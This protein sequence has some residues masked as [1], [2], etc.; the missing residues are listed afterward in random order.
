M[1]LSNDIGI[2]NSLSQNR[3]EEFGFDLF[4][5]FVI[6]PI[7]ET[8]DFN[9]SAKSKI[10]I[11]GRG[12]GKTMLLRYLSHQTTFSGLKK[13]I[14][15]QEV[16][17]IGLYWKV[18]TH[19][20]YQ[21]QKRG[22]ESDIWES[23]FEHLIT[24]VLSLELI[25]SLESIADSN[26]S[27]FSKANLSNIKFGKLLEPFKITKDCDITDLKKHLKSELSNFHFW[28]RNVRKGICPQFLPKL[29]FV[30]LVEHVKSE[31][32]GLENSNFNIYIDE[33]ENLV[34]YQ[35]RI[36]NTWVKHSE[37]P[38]IFHLAMKRNAFKIRN[39]IGNESLS[40][41]H[42]YRIH[43]LEENFINHKDFMVFSA[44]I[45]IYRLQSQSDLIKEKFDSDLL[46]DPEKYQL[47]KDEK[48]QN[49]ILSIVE[50]IF[51]T[52]SHKDLANDIS[53]DAKLNKRINE[54]LKQ[55]LELR[56]SEL[57][58]SDFIFNT[59]MRVTLVCLS[60]LYREKISPN[61]LLIEVEKEKKGLKS[62]FSSSTGWVSN[63]FIG[64]YLLF[65][66]SLNRVCPLYTGF[67][68]YCIMSNGNIRH[69]TE[70]CHKAFLR[71]SDKNSSDSIVDIWNVEIL[72]QANASKQASTTFLNEIKTFGRHGNKLHTFTLRLG[73]LFSLAQKNKKQ[74]EP[75]QNH[76]SVSGGST[77]IGEEFTELIG[78]ALKWSVLFEQKSTK[79]KASHNPELKEYVLNPIYAPYF[80]ISYRKK[81]KLE[82]S[83]TTLETL[84][85]G[86]LDEF[87]TLLKRYRD[88]W[89]IDTK[90]GEAYDL[91]SNLNL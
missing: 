53:K 60:L 42:D 15:K 29:L 70:L 52:R 54:K 38:I 88:K 68:T 2:S 27:D 30:S 40:N 73:A 84:I 37:N 86:S 25:K 16:E 66:S 12:C 19:V 4:Q 74:S 32:K 47:R 67:R 26:Y 90:G 56:R 28:L 33:Y 51:P 57:S 91:F 36:V 50:R 18:D 72:D 11:G 6:P 21:L 7:F 62:K 75:E 83:K 59:D 1:S 24:I 63:N 48:Y 87:E 82:I 3:A 65:Y 39:T 43:D 20:V 69:L 55:I 49:Q 71:A 76:F 31:V 13:E 46:K 10:F 17:N 14:S 77:Q 81:R 35:Q 23:A 80:H 41:V 89:N 8:L 5:D 9:K 45:L 22:L 58:P 44:E 78:E 64:S 79:M 34:E 85:S 61:K